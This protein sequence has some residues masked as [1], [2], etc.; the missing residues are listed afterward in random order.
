MPIPPNHRCRQ[1]SSSSGWVWHQL[2]GR[3]GDSAL[4]AAL[5]MHAPRIASVRVPGSPHSRS[6][7]YPRIVDSDQHPQ[8]LGAASVQAAMDRLVFAA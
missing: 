5:I 2:R 3:L 1:Y 4:R 7:G 6:T 8:V